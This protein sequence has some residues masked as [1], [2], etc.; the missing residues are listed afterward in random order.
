MK[1]LRVCYSKDLP[2]L[3]NRNNDYIYLAYDKLALFIGKN[4]YY[5]PFII[6]ERIPADPIPGCLYIQFDGFVLCLIKD[7]VEIFARVENIDQMNM[8]RE[9]GTMYF[10][11][12]ER[13]YLDPQFRT[14][15][16]PYHNGTYSMTVD[17]ARNLKINKNTVIR[18]DQET[19]SFYME[20]DHVGFPDLRGFR[21]RE[22]DSVSIQVNEHCVHANVK[23]SKAHGNLLRVLNGGLF[24]NVDNKIT[25]EQFKAV[26]QLYEE[27]KYKSENILK[28]I[29]DVLKD[30]KD[31]LPDPD[32]LVTEDTILHLITEAIRDNYADIEAMINYYKEV[33]SKLDDMKDECRAY[34]D[35]VFNEKKEEIEWYAKHAFSDVWGK[36]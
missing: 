17:V 33:E 31:N 3:Q 23:I 15:Q 16:L 21:G 7:D 32:T 19:E 26:R 25:I 20:G 5:D 2:D 34:T 30:V 11:H 14:L 35:Q 12:A 8:L 22:T 36:F 24:A 1:T 10:V 4:M 28:E 18:Y 29:E 13:R 6:C 9:I 27:Y